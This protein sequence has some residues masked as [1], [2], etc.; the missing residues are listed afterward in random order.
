MTVSVLLWLL[1]VLVLIFA[2]GRRTYFDSR[3][4]SW[5][6]TK[7]LWLAILLAA[8]SE[9]HWIVRAYL[10]ANGYAITPGLAALLVFVIGLVAAALYRLGNR[11]TIS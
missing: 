9:I 7:F 11:F 4:R 2:V 10:E 8:A 3:L 5:E 1:F 6:V